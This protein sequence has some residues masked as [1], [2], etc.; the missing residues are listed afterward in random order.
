[1]RRIAGVAERVKIPVYLAGGAVR[2]ILLNRAATDLDFLVLGPAHT[3]AERV[4]TELGGGKVVKFPKFKTAFFAYENRK[5]EF[6][7]P[8]VPEQG[9]SEADWVAGDLRG[10]D[11]TI[12]AAAARLNSEVDTL[13]ISDPCGGVE[14][15][16]RRI[17]RTPL[18]PE[19][20]FGDDPIRIMRAARFAAGFN[21]RMVPGLMEAMRDGLGGLQRVAAERLGMELWKILELPRPSRALKTLFAVGAFGVFLPEASRLSGVEKRGKFNHKDILLHS[22][23]VLDNVASS[24]GDTVTR[25]AALVHDVAKPLTKRFDPVDGF[26]FHGHEDLGSRM[27]KRIAERLRYSRDT[28]KLA[29]KL[30]GLHMRPVNLAGQEVTDSGIRRLMTQAGEDLDLLLILCRADITSGNP[31]KVKRYLENFDGMVARMGEVREKDEMRAFQS[32]VRGDEIMA[33]LNIPPGPLVGKIKKIIEEAIL[34]GIIPN[35]YEAAKEY[36][37]GHWE[38][39]VENE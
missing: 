21:L 16:Q 19:R 5:L 14:D 31:R 4:R 7:E 26:T 9:L 15:L 18:L 36:F 30:T 17:L 35:E 2:D 39:W 27:V 34:E 24:G 28:A 23:K 33:T 22:F 6:S 11:F 20:T 29:A 12:N 25:F 8:R 37:L 10:R 1:M 13:E 32:P 38:E 3:V